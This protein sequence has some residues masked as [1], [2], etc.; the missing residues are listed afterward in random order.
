MPN[1]QYHKEY[2]QKNKKRIYRLRKIRIQKKR[3]KWNKVYLT[4]K[5]LTIIF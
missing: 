5:D 1:N 3:D 2:Y 4:K